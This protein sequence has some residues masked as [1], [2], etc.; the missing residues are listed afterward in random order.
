MRAKRSAGKADAWYKRA[1]EVEEREGRSVDVVG[2][3]ERLW[4]IRLHAFLERALASGSVHWSELAKGIALVLVAPP[5]D[6][7][8]AE[9]LKRSKAL[10]MSQ[11]RAKAIRRLLAE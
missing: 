10:P 9:L 6:A 5:G 7:D 1:L 4:R 3:A 2:R 11:S 8:A